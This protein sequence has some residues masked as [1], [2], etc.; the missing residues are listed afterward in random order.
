MWLSSPSHKSRLQ[1]KT[2]TSRS[3]HSSSQ[4]RPGLTQTRASQ[5]TTHR[6]NKIKSK[7]KMAEASLEPKLSTKKLSLSG[8][9]PLES[10]SSISPS[11]RKTRRKGSPLY[12]RWRLKVSKVWVRGITTITDRVRVI[13]R[14]INIC[15]FIKAQ[16]QKIALS[17]I[18]S[19]KDNANVI[20]LE[21]YG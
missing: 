4:I 20:S 16:K 10:L 17:I 12:R 13:L 14:M 21:S 6:K 1:H 3:S 11:N 9:K 18:W 15:H 5:R 19:G 2:T 7:I 8:V